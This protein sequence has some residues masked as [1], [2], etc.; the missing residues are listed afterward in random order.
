VR[1][2]ASNGGSVEAFVPLLRI[3]DVPDATSIVTCP[4][5]RL[6]IGEPMTCNI[7]AR[8]EGH[9][10]DTLSR[11]FTVQ[12]GSLGA[13]TPL[14]ALALVKEYATIEAK[15]TSKIKKYRRPGIIDILIDSILSL[16]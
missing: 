16:C 4:R 15:A 10:I 9:D 8:R 1:I 5:H 11:A 3:F 12:C 6:F 14:K 13:V 2:S 7:K